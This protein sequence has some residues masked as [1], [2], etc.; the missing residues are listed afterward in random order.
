MYFSIM[1]QIILYINML[2]QLNIS[3]YLGSKDYPHCCGRKTAKQLS[4]CIINVVHPRKTIPKNTIFSM[5][6][7]LGLLR[8]PHYI[9]YP[10]ISLSKVN[11]STPQVYYLP[12]QQPS[13]SPYTMSKQLRRQPGFEAILKVLAWAR[14]GTQNIK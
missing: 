10:Y 8:L 7:M 1:S 11:Y 6:Q 9:I 3:S 2:Y 5:A 4:N 13:A 12:S 14:S